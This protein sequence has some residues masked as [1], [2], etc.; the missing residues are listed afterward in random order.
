MSG[1]PTAAM[2]RCTGSD[3]VLGLGVAGLSVLGSAVAVKDDIWA[4]PPDLAGPL[5]PSPTE[6]VLLLAGSLPLAL[7]R[8]APVSVLAVCAAAFLGLQGL[9]RPAPLPLGVL[10]ALFTVA[11]RCRPI[12][13]GL[14]A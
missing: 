5:T 11:T 13:S 12:V 7:R 1:A 10:V 4:Q 6:L 14:G 8:V 2:R 3:L 9:G